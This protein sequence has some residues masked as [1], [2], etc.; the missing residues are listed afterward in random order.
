MSK[1]NV[2]DL[3]LKEIIESKHKPKKS[4]VDRDQDMQN[5]F[6]NIESEN[7]SKRKTL[8]ATKSVKSTA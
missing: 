3:N 1:S 8:E 6:K 2:F 4:V 7:A 5:I